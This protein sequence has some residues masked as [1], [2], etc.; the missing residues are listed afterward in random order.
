MKIMKSCLNLSKLR[1]KY[2]RS[3]F[4]TRFSCLLHLDETDSFII[5]LKLF[6]IHTDCS[7]S[8]NARHNGC[9]LK[10]YQSSMSDLRMSFWDPNNLD[11]ATNDHR[12]CA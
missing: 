4:R 10:F 5:R 1:P 11:Q 8:Y 2:C 12:P 7:A 3:F 6:D 9:V